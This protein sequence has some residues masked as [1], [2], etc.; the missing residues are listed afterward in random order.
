MRMYDFRRILA[1]NIRRLSKEKGL[2]QL[3]LSS[4]ANVSAAFI[5]S[6][7]NSQKWVSSKTLAKIC[8]A[9]KV[10]PYELFLTEDIEQEELQI[11]AGD[12]EKMITDIKDI[13]K[14]YSKE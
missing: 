2:S 13:I 4:E 7:E 6:I 9:L 5:N 14:K 1:K 8:E 10:K 11:I 12:H 3:Q